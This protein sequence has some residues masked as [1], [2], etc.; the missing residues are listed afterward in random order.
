MHGPSRAGQG[1]AGQLF[2][3]LRLQLDAEI[4]QIFSEI[5]SAEQKMDGFDT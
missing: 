3:L 5:E 2:A 4:R 1:R